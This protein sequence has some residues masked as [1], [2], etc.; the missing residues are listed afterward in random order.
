M[1]VAW[2]W[3][4]G[5][6][7]VGCLAFRRCWTCTSPSNFTSGE[8]AT[9]TSV[10]LHSRRSLLYS[11]FIFGAPCSRR[12]FP[13]LSLPP[14]LAMPRTNMSFFSRAAELARG[15]LG[16]RATRSSGRGH[17]QTPAMPAPAADGPP[18]AGPRSLAS[19]NSCEDVG[20]A[21]QKDS[22]DRIGVPNGGLRAWLVVLGGFLN[23]MNAFGGTRCPPPVKLAGLPGLPGLLNSFGTFQ[24]RYEGKWEGKSTSDVTWIGSVQASYPR[25]P[26]TRGTVKILMASG[27]AIHPLRGRPVRRPG[28]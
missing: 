4:P 8:Q 20:S 18:D 19:S 12:S 23:F 22:S 6:P 2:C 16:R 26:K 28:L 21:E 9:I 14:G 11:P 13:R 7:A 1:A 3:D 24:A 25:E 10:R 5:A 17:S 15:V 27:A